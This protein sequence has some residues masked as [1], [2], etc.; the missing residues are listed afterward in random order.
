M[1][2]IGAGGDFRMSPVENVVFQ[3][4]RSSATH[5]SLKTVPAFQ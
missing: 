1:K 5:T 2:T 3:R 4:T